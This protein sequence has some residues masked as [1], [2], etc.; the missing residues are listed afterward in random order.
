MIGTLIGVGIVLFTVLPI[1]GW[2][3]GVYN[4]IVSAKQDIQNQWSNIKTEYQRRADMFYNLVQSVK[5][6]AKFEKETM[7]QVTQ[8]RGGINRANKKDEMKEVQGLHTA[9]GRLMVVMEN[10]PTLKSGRQYQQLMEEIRVTEDR[11]N[12][13]RTDYNAIVRDYNT[14]IKE[15]PRNILATTF[16][17]E[18]EQYFMNEEGTDESPKI[19]MNLEEKGSL[20]KETKLQLKK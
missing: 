9:L 14:Y 5:G 13:A 2:T 20:Q 8:A 17:A 15:F 7:V 4:T 10:Y 19:D 11:I 3:I 16:K 1:V 6:H 18:E 12:I